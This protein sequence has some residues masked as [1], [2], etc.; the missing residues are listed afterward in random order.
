M[1]QGHVGWLCKQRWQ[2]GIPLS[3]A[4]WLRRSHSRGRLQRHAHSQSGTGMQALQCTV[5]CRLGTARLAAH[6]AGTGWSGAPHRC[7]GWWTRRRAPQAA[8]TG[9]GAA[10]RR[11]VLEL[12]CRAGAQPPVRLACRWTMIPH[13]EPSRSPKHT[14]RAKGR[15]PSGRLACHSVRRSHGS[16]RSSSM[17]PLPTRVTREGKRRWSEPEKA[18]AVGRGG[19]GREV[20]GV[21]GSW[22]RPAALEQDPAL[23][24]RAQG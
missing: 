17:Y 7:A 3:P 5:T 1:G 12:D 22:A 4:R 8:G 15:K 20:E 13:T 24:C 10:Q 21:G 2:Q 16:G 18:S 14:A 11:P 23:P 9:G 19:R 6:R